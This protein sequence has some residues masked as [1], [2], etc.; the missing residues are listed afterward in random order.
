[1]DGVVSDCGNC[2]CSDTHQQSAREGM[3]D[4]KKRLCKTQQACQ[5]G[6]RKQSDANQPNLRL[7][8]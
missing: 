1:V 6:E 2:A 3:I 7:S 4:R 5:K 8:R